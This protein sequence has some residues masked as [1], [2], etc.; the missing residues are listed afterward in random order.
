M[1]PKQT[2]GSQLLDNVNDFIMN[3]LASQKGM[4]D[5][6][7]KLFGFVLK[8]LITGNNIDWKIPNSWAMSVTYLVL[9]DQQCS[10]TERPH[11]LIIN[12]QSVKEEVMHLRSSYGGHKHLVRW[13]LSGK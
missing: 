7:R 11:Q 12:L 1:N 4:T 9:D 13:I 10:S 2:I 5:E 6:K 3:C 8:I